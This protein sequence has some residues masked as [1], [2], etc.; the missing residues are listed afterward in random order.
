M[1]D[2]VNTINGTQQISFE[3][4]SRNPLLNEEEYQKQQTI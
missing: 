1:S 2:N 4:S 3:S